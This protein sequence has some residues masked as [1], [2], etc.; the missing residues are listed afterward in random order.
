MAATTG[1]ILE[2]PTAI[3]ILVVLGGGVIAYLVRKVDKLEKT[4]SSMQDKRDSDFKM[5]L[6]SHK[7]TVS[8]VSANSAIMHELRDSVKDVPE[9][10]SK[11][12]SVDIGRI[13]NSLQVI[14]DEVTTRRKL[15]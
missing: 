15:T 3:T 7:E 13:D 11:K 4:C 12:M 10:V 1:V 14:K 5:I 6:D 9:E 2:N 8:V